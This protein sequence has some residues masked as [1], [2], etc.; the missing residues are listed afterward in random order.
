MNLFHYLRIAL[1]H[2]LLWP[3]LRDELRVVRPH[4]FP[5]RQ[6]PSR[7]QYLNPD[8][9]KRLYGLHLTLLE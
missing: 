5:T 8:C 1:N 3:D 2:F 9:R 7:Y 6:C 4:V